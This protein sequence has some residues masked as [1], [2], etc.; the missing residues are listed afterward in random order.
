MLNEYAERSD[1]M[2]AQ[3]KTYGCD[4]NQCYGPY[5]LMSLGEAKSQYLE[6]NNYEGL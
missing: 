2:E 4:E 6:I 3:I 1:C 5:I